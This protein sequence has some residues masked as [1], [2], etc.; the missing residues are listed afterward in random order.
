MP[1]ICVCHVPKCAG[2]ALV[3]AIKGHYSFVD[4][5][6]FPDFHMNLEASGVASEATAVPITQVRE[7]VLAYTLA[8]GRHKYAGG[9]VPCRPQ[10]VDTFCDRWS[11]ITV[12]R[13]PVERW[14]SGYVYDRYKTE[15]WSKLD[16]DIEAYLSSEAG[17]LSGRAYLWYFSS[18]PQDAAIRE[19]EPYVAEAEA[20]LR[21]FALVGSTE[22]MPALAERFGEVFGKPLKIKSVNRTP[23]PEAKRAIVT[24]A[25]LMARIREVCEPDA[26]L[27]SRLR[28]SGFL[29]APLPR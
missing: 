23:N 21:R 15:S 4:R 17:I 7:E 27:Y 3:D 14:I 18:M 13:D 24:N 2:S 11:F 20:N 12:L 9:H 22:N 5:T 10:L 16:A 19:V 6:L 29:P 28:E 25:G 8:V 1:R 26:L